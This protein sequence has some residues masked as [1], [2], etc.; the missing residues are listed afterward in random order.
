MPTGR[1]LI[2]DDSKTVRLKLRKAVEALGNQAF[3]VSDGQAALDTL[4]DTAIDVVLLDILMPVMDGFEVLKTLK[5]TR[6]TKDIPVI[7]ISGLD[8]MSSVVRAIELGAEDFL[9]KDFEPTLLNARLSACIEKKRL[10]DVERE[11]LMRLAKL[12]HAAAALESGRFDPSKL[13]LQDIAR[14]DDGLGKLAGVFSAMAQKV[15]ERE[16][17]L[18]QNLRTRQGTLLLIACGVLWGLIVPLSKMASNISPNPI[19]LSILVGIVGATITISYSLYRGT[20][21]KLSSFTRSD[22][23]YVMVWAFLFMVVNQILIFWLAGLLP[24]FM[25]SIVIV[26]EGFGVF[27]FAAIMGI[28]APKVKRFAGLGLGLVGVAVIIIFGES[29]SITGHWG[30]I[31][32]ALLIPITYAI[33]DLYIAQK[34]PPL[35]DNTALFG[36]ASIVGILMLLPLAFIFDDFIPLNLLAGKA[37]A[38]VVMI[39]VAAALATISFVYLISSTGAV[40]A[41]Q[42]AYAVTAAGIGWSVLLLG[43]H[44]PFLT[45]VALGLIIVGLIM[46][47]PKQEADEEPPQIV[48]NIEDVFV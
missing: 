28:E 1:I 4:K 43:E 10:R 34:R 9:P 39:G 45:W 19:G 14:K 37:G 24:A 31:F 46:V 17:R 16:C 38:L 44:I 36:V 29:A 32:V 41:S 15:Y 12:T 2:V 27:L 11:Y 33:E 25:V 18:K 6:Q 7:V 5:S 30:W 26:L 23:T 42:N 20:F 40:F 48:A 35:L 47:E 3:A 8:E 13:G 22:W 21:P